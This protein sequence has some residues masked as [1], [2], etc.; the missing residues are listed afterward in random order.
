MNRVLIIAFLSI[1]CFGSLRAQDRSDLEKRKASTQKDIQIAKELL[2]QTSSKKKNSIQRV[3][4]LNRGIKSRV[5]LIHS[6]EQEID[7][8]DN[9]IDLLEKRILEINLD[10]A[11]GREEYAKIVYAIYKNHTEEEKLMYLLASQ[12]INQFY[13]RVKYLKY[14]TDYREK[15][16]EELK[17]L[18]KDLEQETSDL[19]KIRNEK[20]SLLKEK[21]SENRN[22]LRERNLKN[23]IIRSL[24]QNERQ[25]RKDIQAKE[26]IQRELE[27][28]IRRIIE[29]E[30]TK[31]GNNSLYSSLTPEQKLL[32]NNFE[33]NKGRLPWPVER[34]I[35]TASFGLID[36]DVPG[37]KIQN[38]GLDFTANGNSIARAIFDGEVTSIFAILGANYA[39]IVMHGEYLSVYQ[40]LENLQVEVGDKLVTKQVIGTIHSEDGVSVLPFQIWK[41][42]VILNPSL[43]LSK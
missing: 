17:L 36:H 3:S 34:G 6:I 16:V 43:W 2:E 13:Q 25:I 5:N 35:V 42:K 41:S 9:D 8:M 30:A 15:K 19:L 11:K 37:V 40:N 7:G 1:F 21:E 24:T 23:G 32:G 26:K 22:L 14:L 10:I 28:K 38:N 39:V 29:E 31:R 4:I 33:Q 27:A 12:N 20:A 18:T